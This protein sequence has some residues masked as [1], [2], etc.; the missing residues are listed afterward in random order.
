M[1]RMWQP[2]RFR[3]GDYWPELAERFNELANKV[4]AERKIKVASGRI[5]G[6]SRDGDSVLSLP[7][8]APPNGVQS[9]TK[10]WLSVPI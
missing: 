1:E 7:V 2:L 3:D 9:C 8:L 6:S 5:R 10:H 4:Q